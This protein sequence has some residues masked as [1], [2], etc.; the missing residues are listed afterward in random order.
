MFSSLLF[1]F[2]CQSV[3]EIAN[4]Y[5]ISIKQKHTHTHTF[6]MNRFLIWFLFQNCI[7]FHFIT[8]NC[9]NEVNW[10]EFGNKPVK[11]MEW[12]MHVVVYRLVVSSVQFACAMY[13]CDWSTGY[14]IEQTLD[15]QTIVKT[16][17]CNKWKSISINR[18]TFFQVYSNL[19][20]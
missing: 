19:P 6:Q 14:W 2:D 1:E 17:H 10:Y 12:T 11:Q 8:S 3:K 7:S 20:K 18:N 4:E 16:A 15:R 13:E 5:K 9:L